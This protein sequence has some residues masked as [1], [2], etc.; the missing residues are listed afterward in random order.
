MALGVSGKPEDDFIEF[1]KRKSRAAVRLIEDTSTWWTQKWLQ[2]TKSW[3]KHLE[4]DAQRQVQH[5]VDGVPVDMVASSFSW[6][7]LLAKWRHRDFLEA[8]R[9]YFVQI[10]PQVRVS[11][12]TGLRGGRGKV[13][14]RW[15]DGVDYAE[16]MLS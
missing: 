9:S 7:P 13:H 8:Q 3:S 14:M 10:A 6:A 1:R 5:F 15:Q 2:R 4:R 11:S 12:R 16:R